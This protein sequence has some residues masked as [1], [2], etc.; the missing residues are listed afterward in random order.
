MQEGRG[1]DTSPKR[2]PFVYTNVKP[3]EGGEEGRAYQLNETALQQVLANQHVRDLL[4]AAAGGGLG[5]MGVDYKIDSIHHL[6]QTHSSWFERHIDKHA[7]G[8]LDF[9]IICMVGVDKLVSIPSSRTAS[10][11]QVR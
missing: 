1:A 11:S 4:S 10:I 7:S 6:H 2:V 3:E 8:S 5:R 9:A